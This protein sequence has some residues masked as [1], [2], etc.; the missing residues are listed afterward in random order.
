V[1]NP[2]PLVYTVRKAVR[3]TPAQYEGLRRYAIDHDTA[4]SI[5]LREAALKLIGRP[6]LSLADE[7]AF[8]IGNMLARSD[9]RARRRSNRQSV[10]LVLCNLTDAQYKALE[11][12]AA[13]HRLAT[14]AVLRNA[15]LARA[16]LDPALPPAANA[17]HPGR[18]LGSRWRST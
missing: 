18:P 17:R 13:K 8:P 7:T 1:A 6:E 4:V 14:S 5:V 3:V 2:R 16:R 11:R 9:R 12:Y 15:G 10:V